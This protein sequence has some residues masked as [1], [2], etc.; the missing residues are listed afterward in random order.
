MIRACLALGVLFSASGEAAEIGPPIAY[1]VGNKVYL[2][3]SDGSS[4]KQLYSGGSR[5]AIFGVQLKPGG[6]EVAFEETACCSMPTSS[7]LK[8][9]RY[10][11]AGVRLGTP[12]SLTVCGRISDIA[13]HPSDG[14]LLYISTCNQPLKRLNS[15]SMASTNVTLSSKPS[16]V[17]WL[18]NGSEL[19]Y[20]AAAKIWRVSIASSNSPTAVGNAD[21]VQTLDAGNVSNRAI[22]TD[23]C[24]GMLQLLDLSTGQS[25]A[26]RQGEGPRF[27]PSD[28]E[29]A[30]LSP[31]SS[32][33]RYLLISKIDGSGTQT[34]IGSRTKYL[35]LDWRK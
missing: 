20:A 21:C 14:S 17:S 2:A 33:G 22:W 3:A 34:R 23:A 9:V 5:S 25:V 26:L 18:P 6:G 28:S 1:S 19:I 24:K 15:T 16:K 8:I 31:L 7:L 30:Y 32:S 11:N 27:S 4:I 35:S 10:D 12:A 13:Y 29:Y